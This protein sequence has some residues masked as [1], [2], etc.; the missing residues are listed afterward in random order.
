[1]GLR[2]VV[3]CAERWRSITKGDWVYKKKSQERVTCKS[4][5]MWKIVFPTLFGA[6]GKE[7]REN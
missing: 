1:V 6:D 7:N 5:A 4:G 2:I 3:A